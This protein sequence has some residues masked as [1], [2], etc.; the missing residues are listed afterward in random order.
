[1][2]DE[3]SDLQ[4]IRQTLADI[5]TRAQSLRW[6]AERPW[7]VQ[8]HVWV[9]GGVVTIDLHDLNAAL[10]KAVLREAAA[11]AESLECGGLLFVT[12]RG[13]HSI[14]VPVLRQVMVGG[15]G[16]L[17]RDRGWRHRDVGSGRVLL[18]VDEARIPARYRAGTPLWVVGFFGVFIAALSWTL[19]PPVGI[20]LLAVA[21]WFAWTVRR[22][23]A[24]E[25]GPPGEE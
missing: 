11:C 16:R 21:A 22:A 6:A 2:H 5:Q 12:G 13:R 24:T 7:T 3:T 19:P 10:T 9:D 1:M 17:E 4:T 23:G 8:T 15:L 14:G 20:P 25:R 18:V